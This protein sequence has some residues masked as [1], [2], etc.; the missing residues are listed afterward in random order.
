[1]NGYAFMAFLKVFYEQAE[2]RDFGICQGEQVR[3]HLIVEILN[4]E[5]SKKS[6]LRS[7]GTR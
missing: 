1:M 2:H 4:K 6:H 7:S 5:L 3:E